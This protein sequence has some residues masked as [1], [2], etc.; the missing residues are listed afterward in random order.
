MADLFLY[1][2]G[3]LD[4]SGLS[5]LKSLREL[6]PELTA[7]KSGYS[8]MLD[9][10]EQGHLPKY[11]KKQNQKVLRSTGCQYADEVLVPAI[12]KYGKFVDQEMVV[13]F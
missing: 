3:D 11:S 2:W 5:I 7:W 1:F 9:V 13:T 6:F 4:F 12:L 10:I 8:P